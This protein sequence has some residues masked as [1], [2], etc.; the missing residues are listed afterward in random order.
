MASSRGNLTRCVGLCG[1]DWLFGCNSLDQ[2][3]RP[4]PVALSHCCCKI[5][6]LRLAL[7]RREE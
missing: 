5:E 2:L 3:V 6:I 1:N 7:R 4:C